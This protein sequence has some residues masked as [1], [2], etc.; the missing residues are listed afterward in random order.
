MVSGCFLKI[1]LPL[2]L[3]MYSLSRKRNKIKNHND[4]GL[5]EI[6]F[7]YLTSPFEFQSIKFESDLPQIFP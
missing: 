1:I 7:W 5:F 3:L 4:L 6:S 2:H